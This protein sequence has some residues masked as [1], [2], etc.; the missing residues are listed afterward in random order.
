MKLCIIELYSVC[1]PPLSQRVISM[2]ILLSICTMMQH[3]CTTLSMV[4]SA[5]QPKTK[6]FLN[7]YMSP[8]RIFL[9]LLDGKSAT[10]LMMDEHIE[11]KRGTV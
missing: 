2:A 5:V 1:I 7:V 4:P 10:K 6:E 9:F 11:I 3:Q 8:R